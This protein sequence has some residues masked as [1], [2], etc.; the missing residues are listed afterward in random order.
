MTDESTSGIQDILLDVALELERARELDRLLPLVLRRI[1]EVLN[2][3][4]AFLVLYDVNG[5]LEHAVVH[6]L[7]WG[8]QGH[9]LPISSELIRRVIENDELLLI[10]DASTH[11][12]F[13]NRGSIQD[14]EVRFMVGVPI[15]VEGRVTGVLC[16][17]SHRASKRLTHDDST[18][19]RALSKLVGTAIENAQHFEEQRLRSHL[20]EQLIR[21]FRTPLSVITLNASLL[22]QVS[23]P[24]SEDA[25]EMA[26]DIAAS[27]QRMSQLIENTI[28]LVRIDGDLSPP[29]PAPFDVLRE[30]PR[31]LQLCEVIA[32]PLNLHIEPAIPAV[33]PSILT[34]SEWLWIALDGLLFHALKHSFRGTTIRVGGTTRDNSGPQEVLRT[35][36]RASTSV[37]RRL[38]A[39]VPQQGAPFVELIIEHRGPLIPVEAVPVMF[40]ASTHLRTSKSTLSGAGLGLAIV[41]QCARQLGGSLWYRVTDT[42]LSEFHIT[43]PT[44]I[45]AG[46][47]K[48]SVE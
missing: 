33:F 34:V 40:D 48:A 8:G 14:L 10:A 19:L 11:D 31:H 7:T 38:P 6:N 5:E 20:L 22:G 35:I 15:H 24:E 23:D 27:A 4:H 3:D 25:H 2:A 16:A 9:P 18:R 47:P 30:V 28:E 37:F 45:V 12:E 36:G 42:E 39:V 26:Q 32:R 46:K 21:E 13:K 17:D 43:F 29:T 44:A 41:A 1:S